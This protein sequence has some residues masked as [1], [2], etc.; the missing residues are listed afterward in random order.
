[1][2]R[3]YRKAFSVASE[4]LYLALMMALWTGQRQGDLL[5]LPW[6]AYD[7]TTIRLTQSKIGK[8]VSIKVGFPLKALLDQTTRRST[9]ILTNQK[10]V[11]WTSDGLRTSWGKMVAKA[12]IEGLR[13]HD[14]RGSTVTRLA[15]E[16]APP[17]EIAS[18]TGHS[19][20]DVCNILDRHYLGERTALAEM[21]IKRLERK[22][23]RQ[24]KHLKAIK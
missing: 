13:F 23:R 17:Q 4:Q 3:R 9:M 11:P 24:K 5:E 22:E 7:G 10:G 8:A 20:Q 2:R 18:V 21:A 19:L 14:L 15:L 16:G 12:K 6:C 1:V